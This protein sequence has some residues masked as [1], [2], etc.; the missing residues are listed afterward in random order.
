M[1]QAI[2]RHENGRGPLATGNTWYD[3]ATL[4]KGL[5]LAGVVPATP[6]AANI[7]VTKET[8]GATA[9]GGAGVAQIAEVLTSIPADTLAQAGQHLNG[10]SG[11]RL[12]IGVALIAAAVL[13]AWSQ[14]KR[15]R[16]GTL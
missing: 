7:P 12:G 16:D 11:I 15:Y 2:I 6:T 9:T 13:I 1:V 14:V 8:I 4:N 3:E 10:S 5:A